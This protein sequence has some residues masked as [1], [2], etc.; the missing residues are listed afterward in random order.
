MRVLLDTSYLYKL[1]EARGKFSDVERRFFV[2]QEAQLYVSAVSI[3]EIRLKYR[4]LHPSGERKSPYD[5]NDVIDALKEQGVIFL[6]MTMTHAAH[7]L[8]IP[9]PHKDSSSF[10]PRKRALN[11]SPPIFGSSGIPWPSRRREIQFME[12][13]QSSNGPGAFPQ[14]RPPV[15]DECLSALKRTCA[16]A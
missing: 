3:W 2:E 9:I 10:R 1:M 15:R 14:G 11:F 8:E 13:S 7:E 6:P 16:R 12:A 5:P 4:A